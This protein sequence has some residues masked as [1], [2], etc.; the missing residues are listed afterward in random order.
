VPARPVGGEAAA[1]GDHPREALETAAECAWPVGELAGRVR[2]GERR[3]VQ[4]MVS[5]DEERS[6][7]I[8]RVR[9]RPF[10]VSDMR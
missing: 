4:A 6:D 10:A 2:A 5:L 7:R 3:G 9:S 8:E 1:L